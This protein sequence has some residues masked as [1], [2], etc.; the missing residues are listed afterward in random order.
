[1]SGPRFASRFAKFS[2]PIGALF[3]FLGLS[4]RPIM[5]QSIQALRGE[6]TAKARDET[7]QG[8]EIVGECLTASG[9]DIAF[10]TVSIGAYTYGSKTVVVPLELL[11][12]PRVDIEPTINVA[13]ATRITNRHFATGTGQPRGVVTAAAGRTGAV[14]YDDLEHA[15]DPACR[16]DGRFMFHDATLE[17]LKKLRDSQGRPLWRRW[18]PPRSL[19]FGDLK[20]DLIRDVMAVTLFRFADSKD[21]EKG[22]VAF[23]ARSTPATTPSRRSSTRRAEAGARSARP[24]GTGRSPRSLLRAR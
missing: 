5:T 14:T 2:A 24:P 22:Q 3:A 21:L 8:G 15:V 9:Q 12:D 10:G 19:L 7:G 13:L 18:A 23:L 4:R 16:G 17:A 6:R 1:M 11:Q 20:T